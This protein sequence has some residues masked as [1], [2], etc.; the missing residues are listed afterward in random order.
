VPTVPIAPSFVAVRVG[1]GRH[2]VAFEYHPWRTEW[3]VMEG[4]L[5]LVVLQLSVA[6]SA[7]RR[8]RTRSVPEHPSPTAARG[9]M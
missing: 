7:R 6:R 8:A 5:G 1:P 2:L 4:A 3:L 9:R